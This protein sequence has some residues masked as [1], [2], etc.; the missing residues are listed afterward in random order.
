MD[1]RFDGDQEARGCTTALAPVPPCVPVA[2]PATAF[3]RRSFREEPV[4]RANQLVVVE[5]LNNGNLPPSQRSE[6]RRRELVGHVVEMGDVD[7]LGRQERV[8]ATVRRARGDN[9]R[10]GGEGRAGASAAV[11]RDVRH[12]VPGLRRGTIRGMAHREGEDAVSALAEQ[13]LE[14]EIVALASAAHVVELVYV[15]NRARTDHRTASRPPPDLAR[16]GSCALQPVHARHTQILSYALGDGKA[17]DCCVI[18]CRTRGR[19]GYG[20]VCR[21]ACGSSDA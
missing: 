12:E 3:A 10:R 4:V 16:S 20:L 21:G 8:D 19:K 17:T 9:T 5:R 2:A 18:V 7:A 6:N 1:A 13:F 15:E 14:V 11:P